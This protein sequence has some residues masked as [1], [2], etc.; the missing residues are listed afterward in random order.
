MPKCIERLFPLNAR[1]AQHIQ[2]GNGKIIELMDF[3]V[4]VRAPFDL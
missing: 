4:S 2:N 1:V 3:F